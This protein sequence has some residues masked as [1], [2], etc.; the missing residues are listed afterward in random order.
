MAGRSLGHINEQM[1]DVELLAKWWSLVMIQSD[2][3]I[4]ETERLLLC[5]MLVFVRWL[6]TRKPSAGVY[7]SVVK[8]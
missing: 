5:E 8:E 7:V 6:L 3:R 1:L 2:R 4:Q